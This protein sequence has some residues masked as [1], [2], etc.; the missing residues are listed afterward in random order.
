M[1]FQGGKRKQLGC[2]NRPEG[3]YSE[4][5]MKEV[6]ESQWGVTDAERPFRV[7]EG[8][9]SRPLVKELSFGQ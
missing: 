5:E 8:P 9:K 7:W 4:R 2:G 3:V 1:K 6:L